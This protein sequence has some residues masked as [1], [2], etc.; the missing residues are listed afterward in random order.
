MNLPKWK[1]K[2]QDGVE[3]DTKFEFPFGAGKPRSKRL[4]IFAEYMKFFQSKVGFKLSP[5][6]WGY[7]LEG[8]GLIT[9]SEFDKVASAINECRKKGYLPIDFVASEGA[10][11][12]RGVEVPTGDIG[13][14]VKRYIS[15]ALNNSDYYTPD[16]WEGEKYY[17]QLLVEKVDL[18]TLFRPVCRDYHIPV[19]NARGWSS[20]HQKW[21]IL[22]RFQAAEKIGLKPVLLYCGDFDPYG[23][24]I[25]DYMMKQ[26]LELY[27]ATN[28]DPRKIKIDRFGLNYEYIIEN[29]LTWIDNLESGFG[30]DMTTLN[31]SI[32][33]G[34]IAKYGERKCEA[35]A[36]VVRPHAARK[37]CRKAIIKYLK[38]GAKQRFKDKKLASDV[39]INAFMQDNGIL[40]PL[41]KIADALKIKKEVTPPEDVDE[42]E[43]E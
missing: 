17:I 25:S 9:K 28:Y 13:D 34:Y 11:E 29:R 39:K 24:A 4:A 10:R 43:L 33:Q 41:Q 35:N 8:F 2:F 27:P 32:V 20:I 36:L 23:M 15:A 14:H 7:Q 42:D 38:D 30:T 6:G 40:E 1:I 16:W 26:F 31:N 21:D 37:L 19:A 22:K 3:V 18:V 12:F 5:R